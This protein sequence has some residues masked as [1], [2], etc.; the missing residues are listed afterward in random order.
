MAI[1]SYQVDWPGVDSMNIFNPILPDTRVNFYNATDK[2]GIDGVPSVAF[3]GVVVGYNEK[4][5]AYG[6]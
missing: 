5:D 4:Q 2:N 6:N 3:N 1:I